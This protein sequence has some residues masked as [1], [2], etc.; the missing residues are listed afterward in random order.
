MECNDDCPAGRFCQNKL[1]T[2]K[3]YASDLQ[4]FK[5]PG[6]GCGL[7]TLSFIPSGTFIM[8]YVGEVISHDGMTKRVQKMG[9]DAHFYFMSLNSE[10]VGT[11]ILI[12]IIFR[13]SMPQEREIFRDL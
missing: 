8:E 11:S 13:L 2:K 12:K 9:P 7:K 3:L 6:K 5:S 10:Q 1:F 4:V